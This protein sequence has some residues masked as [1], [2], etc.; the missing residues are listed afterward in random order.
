M[1]SD[2]WLWQNVIMP[3]YRQMYKEADPSADLDKLMEAGK[4]KDQ[5]WF[6]AY[7]LDMERQKQIVDEHI[8]KHKLQLHKTDQRNVSVTVF[9][10]ASPNSSKE[11]WEI[12]LAKRKPDDNQTKT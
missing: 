11:S 9:L 12:L 3:I 1:R 4:T 6:M 5:N 10:G 7:Y 8:A 2:R